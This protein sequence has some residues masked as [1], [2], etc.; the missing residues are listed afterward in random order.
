VQRCAAER[1]AQRPGLD[2]LQHQW[3]RSSDG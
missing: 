1:H 3:L 2:R